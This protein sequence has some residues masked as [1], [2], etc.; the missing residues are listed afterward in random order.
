LVNATN[1]RI[2]LG[3]YDDS[4]GLKRVCPAT[5]ILEN[6]RSEGR[7]IHLEVA[8]VTAKMRMGYARLEV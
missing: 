4:A 7:V 5:V 1:A 3:V 8:V 6:I 2:T